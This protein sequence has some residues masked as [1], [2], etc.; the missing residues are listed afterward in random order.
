MGI[1]NELLDHE[2]PRLTRDAASGRLLQGHHPPQAARNTPWPSG[3]PASGWRSAGATPAPTSG[4]ACSSS[5]PRNIDAMLEAEVRAGPR[6]PRGAGPRPRQPAHRGRPL[7]LALQG[8]RRRIADQVPADRRDRPPR[9]CPARLRP[10]DGAGPRGDGRS[11]PGTTRSPCSDR[12]PTKVDPAREADRLNEARYFLAFSLYRAGRYH[13]AAVIADF[14]ARR[15]PDWDSSLPATE[16]GM[17][18]LA[19]AYEDE[20][21]PG[22]AA[23]LEAARGPGRLHDDRLARR[24][25][26]P[27]SPGSSG[28]TSPSARAATTRPPR[29]TSR[30]RR[31]PT[32]STPSGRPPPPTGGGAWRSA[33]TPRATPSRPR[34]P[35]R[36]R[37]RSNC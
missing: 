37:R 28:A 9:A 16:L 19:L 26:R 18:S 13:E 11:R 29:P 36:P 8:R 27:T 35:P 21:G 33:R 10:G 31:R 12:R 17:S 15:Y 30:S 25:P 1:Y 22:K 20:P 34:P 4:S 14:L 23:D 6:P 7:R 24:R 32:C 3:S 5:W 2:D